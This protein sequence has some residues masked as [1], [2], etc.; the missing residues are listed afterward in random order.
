MDIR[1]IELVASPLQPYHAY[2]VFAGVAVFF[3]GL[4]L[5]VRAM[6]VRDT[7][8]FLVAVRKVGLGFA[9]SS[10]I[11]SWTWAMA[12]M[13]SAAQGYNYG[14][15]GIW[16][17][18]IPNGLAVIAVIP[19][20][21]YLRKNMPHGYTLSQ[22]IYYRFNKNLALYWV[23]IVSMLFGCFIMIL[24]NLK[25]TS[26]VMST[27]YGIDYRLVPI[28]AGLVVMA[29]VAIGGM[30]NSTVT[31][32][33]QTFM[34]TIPAAI[35]VIAVIDKVGGVDVVFNGLTTYKD[36]DYLKWYDP[37]TAF[38]FG[39]TFALGLFSITISD[40]TFW[41]R[42][43]AVKKKYV[44]A[45]FLWGGAWFYGIPICIGILG[46][47]GGALGLDYVNQLG[48]D[49]AAV[50]P[51]VVSHLGLPVWIV[52]L[53]TL[54]ILSACLSTVDAAFMGTSGVVSVDIVKRLYPNITDK[55][56]LAYSRLSVVVV[57]VAAIA[58]IF[59]GLDF[60][61][62]ALASVTLKTAVLFP[63]IIA[64]FWNRAP[65]GGIFWGVILSAV[66]GMFIFVTQGEFY[67]TVT[68]F[69]LST[70]IP[71]IW[72]LIKPEPFNPASLRE[73]KDLSA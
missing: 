14:V 50:G 34:I 29:Y 55:K 23:F 19:F 31:A 72:G 7:H 11:A 62:I 46:L 2:L 12:V 15:S 20:G 73:V 4:A 37:K 26:V 1:S 54:A 41:Q 66:I 16:W 69:V 22:Y 58:V 21:L 47:V 30:W 61:T 33:I 53:Y 6:F 32:A 36:P 9:V 52:V 27:V 13:L 28:L 35:V 5:F 68:I 49:A 57:G 65:A 17:F 63:L 43:W 40:Q 24:I 48:G 10:V 44:A 18:T 39:I 51:Y 64:C 8:D 70:C 3:I 56:L 38:A 45:S 59:T 71:I 25:G 42:I 67:G 60:V